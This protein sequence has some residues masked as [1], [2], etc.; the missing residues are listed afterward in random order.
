MNQLH[1][2]ASLLPLL[3]NMLGAGVNL[4]LFTNLVGTGLNAVLTD[5][6]EETGSGYAVQS[7][8]AS[9][10]TLQSVAGHI[11]QI[12][13]GDVAFTPGTATTFTDYGYFLTDLSNATLLG[14][15]LFDS[16]PVITAYPATL[17]VTPKLSL[18]S[19]YT[20]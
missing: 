2:D 3:N 6:V 7:A 16:G 17:T 4:H 11:G 14:F 5:F 13:A 15:G 20:S 18:Q 12:T 19:K 1:P 10:F 9:A 8:P